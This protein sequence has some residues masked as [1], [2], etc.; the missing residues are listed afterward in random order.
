M[1]NVACLEHSHETIHSSHFGVTPWQMSWRACGF[2]FLCRP[3]CDVGLSNAT[4]GVE[5]SGV[6]SVLRVKLGCELI[7]TSGEGQIVH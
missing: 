1:R 4:R 6:R 7:S 3:V 2:A 5:G